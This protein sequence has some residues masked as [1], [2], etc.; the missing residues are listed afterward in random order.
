M[1]GPLLSPDDFA[2]YRVT[3]PQ[4][5]AVYDQPLYDFNLYPLAGQQQINFF[6][7]AQGAGV[8]SAIGAVVGSP[9]TIA[10]T[11]MTVGNQLPSGKEFLCTAIEVQFFP[12]SSAAANTFLLRQ[13]ADFEAA[14]ADAAVSRM[15]DIQ[16]VY[17][18]GVLIFTVLDRVIRVGTPLSEFPPANRIEGWAALATN[19]AATGVI[20]TANSYAGGVLCELATPVSIQAAVNFNVAISWPAAV[21]LPSGFNGRLGVK[22]HGRMLTATT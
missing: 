7:T 21:A 2:R 16:T 9:K 3:N 11:N 8:T 4:Q 6:T 18:T 12:G 14:A 15:N 17:S 13:Q 1:A 5:A 20:Q 19:A 22:L 10:D